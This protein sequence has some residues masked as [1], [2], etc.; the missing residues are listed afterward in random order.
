MSAVRI[1]NLQEK[2]TRAQ[3]FLD[4][5]GPVGERSPYENVMESVDLSGIKS[6]LNQASQKARRTTATVEHI[7][8]LAEVI[9]TELEQVQ[10]EIQ[11]L[12][13]SRRW[14]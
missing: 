1:F 11:D 9:M 14:P 6:K 4:D 10:R 5:I 12:K 8:V 2:D 13:R 7:I 3:R